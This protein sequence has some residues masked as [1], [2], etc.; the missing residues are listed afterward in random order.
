M[1]DNEIVIK[2]LVDNKADGNL[3]KEHGLSI[4]IEAFNK[5]ILFDTGQG[6]ALI[7]NSSALGCDISL[8]DALILSHGHY[9]HTGGVIDVLKHNPSIR[10]Y[11][12]PMV[13]SERFSVKDGAEPRNISMPSDVSSAIRGLP[14]EQVCWAIRP[15]RIDSNIGLS[16]PVPQ[17]HPL[18]DTGGPFFLDPGAKRPD[19]FEDDMALWMQSD[20]GLIIIT[21]CCHSGLIN[22]VNHV[23][24]VSNNQKV[25]AVIGGFHLKGASTERL[26]ATAEAMLEW[27]I[28]TII[29]CHCTGDGPVAFLKQR[30]GKKIIE[31]YAGLEWKC[32]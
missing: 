20:R 23:C 18:E 24:R 32:D 11:C 27:D 1:T 28:K 31:G 22:T 13:I 21:G 14:K 6:K 16:G 5:K 9:D 29:P 12:H 7:H 25:Y 3:L 19:P 8:A 4:W 15:E 10:M 17:V 26:E 2:I 30:F